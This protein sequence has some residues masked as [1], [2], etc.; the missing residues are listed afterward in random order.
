MVLFQ[1]NA[2][3]LPPSEAFPYLGRTITCN[4]SNCAAVYLNLQKAHRRWGMV[5]RVIE[6]TVETVQAQGEMYKEM[7][8][9]VIYLSER[10]GW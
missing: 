9:L 3:T 10:A 8:K 4:N 6:R 2:E 7:E 5:A 1:I